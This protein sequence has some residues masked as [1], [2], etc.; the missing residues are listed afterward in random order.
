[1]FDG[2]SLRLGVCAKLTVGGGCVGTG[3]RR[4]GGVDIILE[5]RSEVGELE[6][7]VCS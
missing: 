4:R 7:I 2:E 6:T 1:M 5:V 3:P